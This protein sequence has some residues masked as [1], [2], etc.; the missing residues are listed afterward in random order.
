M[1]IDS[2]TYILYKCKILTLIFNKGT[3]L[4][5]ATLRDKVFNYLWNLTEN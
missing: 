4:M 3:E 2:V 1:S 5:F